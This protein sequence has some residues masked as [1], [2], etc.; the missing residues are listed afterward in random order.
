MFQ[1]LICLLFSSK[2]VFA[3][4][5]QIHNYIMLLLYKLCKIKNVRNSGEMQIS[6]HD[7]SSLRCLMQNSDKSVL[8]ILKLYVI[9]TYDKKFLVKLILS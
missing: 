8:Y 6:E 7:H 1:P 2:L 9:K 3:H 4:S 5:L